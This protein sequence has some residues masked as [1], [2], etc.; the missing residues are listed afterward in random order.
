MHVCHRMMRRDM[1]STFGRFWLYADTRINL[2]PVNEEE[3][4]LGGRV[5]ATQ[6]S[7]DFSTFTFANKHYHGAYGEDFLI[8]G[9]FAAEADPENEETLLQIF[10]EGS[11]AVVDR[12]SFKF[13]DSSL[14]Y[15]RSINAD[16][17]DTEIDHAIAPT[18]LN[19]S[20]GQTWT[21]T[22]FYGVGNA[23]M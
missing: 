11:D 3:P 16:V 14:S 2:Q 9:E 22:F 5:H 4:R 8:F 1:E 20:I 7:F 10:E 21:E 6:T 19:A 18:K 23:K 15:S 13:D 12:H 17:K